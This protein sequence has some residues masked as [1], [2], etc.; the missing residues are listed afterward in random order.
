M[1]FSFILANTISSAHSLSVNGFLAEER[2]YDP[3][4]RKNTDTGNVMFYLE[5]DTQLDAVE[6]PQCNESNVVSCKKVW[7]DL[8]LLQT[9]ESITLPDGLKLMLDWRDETH[10]VFHG[11][12]KPN[13]GV[14]AVFSFNGSTVA[15]SL[16]T[17]EGAWRLEGTGDGYWLWIQ[18]GNHFE[19]EDELE[20]DLSADMA[21]DE[22]EPLDENLATSI[23]DAQEDLISNDKKDKTT[24]VTYSV[25]VWVTPEFQSSFASP[26]DMNQF[27][28]LLI[29]ETNQGYINSNIP[30]R[31]KLHNVG[32]HPTLGDGPS[33]DN[34]T[35]VKDLEA[36]LPVEELHQCA[37]A[38][39]LLVKKFRCGAGKLGT[40]KSCET[41]S[42][43]G[44]NC[45]SGQYT[46]AHELGHNFNANHDR[47]QYKN[48]KGDNYG[49]LI[50]GTN[51]RTIMAYN[52]P[53]HKKR[54]N[55]WSNPSIIYE[56]TGS[57]TGVVGKANNARHITKNRFAMAACG[58]EWHIQSKNCVK[59]KSKIPRAPLVCP[60]KSWSRTYTLR[61]GEHVVY[62]TQ[63]TKRY[64]RNVDCKV[65]FEKLEGETCSL[66]I[67]CSKFKIRNKNKKC[68][69]TGDFLQVNG[70]RYCKT[71][72][73]RIIHSGSKMKTLF[74][75]GKKSKGD[76]GAECIAECI[77]TNS[78]K[79]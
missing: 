19:E 76:P 6:P 53:D 25:M 3:Q 79:P 67:S 21:D 41:Y 5:K 1:L 12:T 15:G 10:A 77:P 27:I 23:K 46:F 9:V 11:V 75:S 8:G 68:K 60:G 16:H 54:V 26:E 38:V 49:H 32:V 61:A 37:D 72:A 20:E 4:S 43:S 55:Y 64:G 52:N 62:K 66:A 73:P 18:Y 74:K 47:G 39:V 17:P 35:R 45:A 50:Q 34:A 42:V 31:V 14:E 56:D 28:D 70:K 71:E 29:T 22:E 36:S 65:T 24:I 51:F 30:V 69:K 40:T 78:R 48:P 59:K 57:P 58:N 2:V 33:K 13:F 7:L 44:K 63:N